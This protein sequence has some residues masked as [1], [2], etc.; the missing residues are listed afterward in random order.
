MF[1]QFIDKIPGADVYLVT[2]FLTFLAFFSVVGIYLMVV[3]KNHMQRIS[4][5]PLDDAQA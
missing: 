1:K 2:S 3:D 5:L 4:E